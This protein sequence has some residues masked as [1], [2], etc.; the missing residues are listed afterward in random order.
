MPRPPPF[1][2]SRSRRWSLC[3]HA[4]SLPITLGAD[5]ASRCASY[6]FSRSSSFLRVLH[7][8]APVHL[9]RLVPQFHCVRVSQYLNLALLSRVTRI[10]QPS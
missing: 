2:V 7:L 3:T 6:Q 8:F 5:S 9:D 4:F 1:P 10:P